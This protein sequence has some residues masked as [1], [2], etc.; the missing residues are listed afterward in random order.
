VITKYGG[1]EGMD[2]VINSNDEIK[3]FQNDLME[4][5]KKMKSNPPVKLNGSVA[6]VQ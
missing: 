2:R 3:D 5:T 6:Y 1:S 4:G